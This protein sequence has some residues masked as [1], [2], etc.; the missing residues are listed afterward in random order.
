LLLN[1][2]TSCV[3]DSKVYLQVHVVWEK[4]YPFYA[5][6][7]SSSH[8]VELLTEATIQASVYIKIK[9]KYSKQ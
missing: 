6:R 2:V 5:E 8:V 3:R 4:V 7:I 9:C 1:V